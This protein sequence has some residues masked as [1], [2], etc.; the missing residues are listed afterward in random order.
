MHIYPDDVAYEVEFSLYGGV[1]DMV[2]ATVL[3][4]QACSVVEA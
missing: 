3:H 2:I 4:S 1:Y